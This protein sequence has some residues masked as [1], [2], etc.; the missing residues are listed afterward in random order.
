MVALPTDWRI[1]LADC[2]PAD[3]ALVLTRRQCVR[4][5]AKQRCRTA[6]RSSTAA[7]ATINTK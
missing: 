5:T 1:E 2:E 6:G 7:A 4:A 3:A